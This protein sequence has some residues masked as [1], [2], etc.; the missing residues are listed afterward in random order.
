MKK[1]GNAKFI[2]FYATEVYLPFST[3][4]DSLR[5]L[6]RRLRRKTDTH[7]Q[8][9]SLPVVKWSS[10]IER[11]PIT[12]HECKK[13][14]GNVRISELGVLSQLARHVPAG[15]T[16]F[17]IGTFDGRTTLNLAVNAPGCTV[18]TL[19]LPP[20]G[21]TRFAVESGEKHYIEKLV[22]GEKFINNSKMFPDAVN[23]I[24]QLYGDSAGF[25]FTPYEGCCDLVFVDGSHAYEYALKDSE[26]AFRLRTPSGVVV[27]HDYGVWEGVTKALE[28]VEEKTSAGLKHIHGTSLV[29]SI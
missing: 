27:W 8:K 17:E 25:D 9:T 11:Q 24:T 29:V 1:P 12:I 20:D 14:D 15:G 18:F 6:S 19:D 2:G 21:S 22:S 5:G 26:T 10:L 16:I 7:E 3:V 23:R 13:A 4:T 28:E